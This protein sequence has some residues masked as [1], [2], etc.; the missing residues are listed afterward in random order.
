MPAKKH[1][2]PRNSNFPQESRVRT[3]HS[4]EASLPVCTYGELFPDGGIIEL[5][6]TAGILKL[7]VFDGKHGTIVPEAQFRGRLF[8]P[9]TLS[10]SIRRAMKFPAECINF[11]STRRL[12]A[13]IQKLFVSNGF[14]EE[15]GLAATYFVFATWFPGALSMAPCLVITGPRLEACFLLQLLACLVRRPLPLAEVTRQSLCSLPMELKPTLIINAGRIGPTALVL[16]RTSNHRN[17]FFSGK[18]GL[19]DLFCAKAVFCGDTI[20]TTILAEGALH[21]S[22][23]P[24]WE[25]LPIIDE[26]SCEEVAQEFQSKFLAYRCHHFL[27]VRESQFDVPEFTSPTRI[28]ARVFGSPIVHAPA[29]QAGLIPLL[30]DHEE[31]QLE[32]S[33]T[34]LR[35]V[36]LEAVLHHCHKE[37]GEWV[38]VGGMTGGITK[39]VHGILKGRGDAT[40]RDAREIGP[41]LRD[42]GLRSKRKS[43]GV[44]YLLDFAV[45]RQVHRLAHG[46]GLLAMRKGEAQ[47]QQCQ[48]ILNGTKVQ[49]GHP[50]E[51][52]KKHG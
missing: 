32:L 1:P 38:H 3:L 36:V 44:M 20:D 27:E 29:L 37:P 23:P 25:Q 30:K 4:P 31:R 21:I 15:A 9:P 16:L 2:V 50:S 46:S 51:S 12:F 40:K 39:T 8:R 49:D 17:A 34:D 45:C 13:A 28:L 7:F 33:W 10:Q 24:S 48:S 35:S 26:N 14:P 41:I 6:Q 42:L 52:E 19:V 47:C 43:G 22:L 18:D 5:V 11:G